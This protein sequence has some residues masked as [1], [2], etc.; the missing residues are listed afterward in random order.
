MTGT[1]Q[2]LVSLLTLAGYFEYNVMLSWMHN[3]ATD[4]DDIS[5]QYN[6]R[7]HRGTQRIGLKTLCPLWLNPVT[8]PLV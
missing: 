7:G 3:T 1:V 2:P 8:L 6:H 5:R 4:I